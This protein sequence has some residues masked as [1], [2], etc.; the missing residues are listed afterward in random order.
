MKYRRVA[1]ICL[2]IAVPINIINIMLKT[3][4]LA[5]IGITLLMLFI[6]MT[7]IFW[8]CPSCNKKLPMSFNINDE[9]DDIY[10]CPY[11]SVKVL[12]GEII[13]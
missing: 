2:F 11:C 12:D 9:I 3:E 1:R 5:I 6:T 13:D 4:L 8:R 7:L 10:I